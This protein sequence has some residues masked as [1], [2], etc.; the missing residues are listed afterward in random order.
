MTKDIF[1]GC[2][3]VVTGGAAGIGWETAALLAQ[4]GAEIVVVDRNLPASDR[5]PALQADLTDNAAVEQAIATAAGLLGGIDV[6]VN[7]AGIDLERPTE[8]VSDA[9]WSRVVDVNLTGPMRVCRAAFPW[10]RASGHGVIVNV[11]SGAGLRPIP[12]RA[13][14]CASKAGLV[15]LTKSLAL[16]WA[17]YGIRANVVC[18]GAVQTDLFAQSYVNAP[19]PEARLAEIRARYP[20]NRIAEPRELAEAIA[21]IAGPAS[22]YVTGVALAVDGGR[23]FH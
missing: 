9:E 2:K 19:D 12:D 13:A 17:E 16:D 15:M 23:S 6:L 4:Q 8:D 22:S 21:W 1:A 5:F 14:Y 3:A 11:A 18:P 20:L 10:L 7:S